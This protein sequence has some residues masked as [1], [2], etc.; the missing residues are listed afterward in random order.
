MDSDV[1]Y[2]TDVIINLGLPYVS[3]GEALIATSRADCST[4]AILIGPLTLRPETFQ[5][6]LVTCIR[7]YVVRP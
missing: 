3:V 6:A 5:L 4:Q 7:V 1:F 2:L